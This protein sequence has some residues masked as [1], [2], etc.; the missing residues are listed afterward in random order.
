MRLIV[1]MTGATGA[2]LGVRLLERLAADPAVETHLVL[3]RWARATIELE[4]GRT[5]RD[6]AELADAVHNSED[7]G[8]AISSGSFRTDGMVVVPCSMKTL[9]G[10]R[11]G[12][13]EGLVSRAADVVLKENRPLVLVPRETPLSH[14]HLENMLA[15]ARM[16][17]RIVPPMPA[18]YN[19]PR[20]TDDIVDH[21]VARILDQFDIEVPSARR[22][23]GMRAARSLR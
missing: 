20:T 16:G 23:S 4:T 1:G 14:I 18:F 5:A 7:Q 22:W 8:A 12:Y 6:V 21:I 13:A 15:L 19:H 17:V 10:I 11:T 9:A 3:S 2:I